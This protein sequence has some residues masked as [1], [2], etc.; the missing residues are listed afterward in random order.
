MLG[1]PAGFGPNIALDEI[2]GVG[3]QGLGLLGPEGPLLLVIGRLPE[4]ASS[5][6]VVVEVESVNEVDPENHVD[7]Q[8]FNQHIV[9]SQGPV[10]NLNGHQIST[11]HLKQ[12]TIGCFEDSRIGLEQLGFQ[13]PWNFIEGLLLY[14][15]DVSSC[16][17]QPHK[18]ST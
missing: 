5:F 7:S 14:A 10:P 6:G 1:A 2:D 18:S 11:F 16:V 9:M 3:V 15:A 12:A 4:E 17:V 8:V 13:V